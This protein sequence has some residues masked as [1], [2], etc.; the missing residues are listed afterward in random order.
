MSRKWFYGR[1]S[2]SRTSKASESD[3]RRGRPQ[4][5]CKAN[6]PRIADLVSRSLPEAMIPDYTAVPDEQNQVLPG[7]V[8][9]SAKR[10]PAPEEQQPAAPVVEPNPKEREPQ[11]EL[12][13]KLRKGIGEARNHPLLP[14]W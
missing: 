4:I 11:H 5:C 13:D 12:C 2:T 10:E 6:V 9:I 7:L 3:S 1:R 8:G 14:A